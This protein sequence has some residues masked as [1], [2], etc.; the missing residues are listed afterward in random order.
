MICGLP[1]V[2][3]AARRPAGGATGRP[4]AGRGATPA[5]HL[6]LGCD[7]PPRQPGHPP[8]GAGGRS[9]AHTTRASSH[10]GHTVTLYSLI[11]LGA[12]RLPRQG[13]RGRLPPAGH[14]P[15][16]RR[17]WTP[18]R[19]TPRS[20]PSS[21]ATTRLAGLRVIGA[22]GPRR[23]SRWWPP[24]ASPAGSRTRSETSWSPWP[25]T[26]RPAAA[27][28]R[29]HRPVHPVGDAAYDDI[30]AMLATIEAAGWTDL[31]SG[32][33]TRD[34]LHCGRTADQRGPQLRIT[35][36]DVGDGVLQAHGASLRPR[37]VNLG[38]GE[39]LSGGV[40]WMLGRP[41]ARLHRESTAD[42]L[43][44]AVGGRGQDDRSFGVSEG[45]A[46]P[47]RSRSRATPARSPSSKA[48]SRHSRSSS[49]ACW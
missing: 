33:S 34:L 2:W 38:V 35:G 27:R 23:S 17:A 42:G 47:S 8:G 44:K 5:A 28:L 49:S 30:R 13:G 25:T 24:T 12:A 6:L 32:L 7:R 31:T 43:T 4:G 1:Y 36:A 41:P 21:S 18:P 9:W 19:S 40:S 15:G 14:P 10:S 3:L 26:R 11:R 37:S 39:Q 29:L 22:F 48:T 46:C 45:L 20:W 16:R